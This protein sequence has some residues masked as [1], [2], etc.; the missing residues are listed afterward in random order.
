MM[1]SICTVY[2]SNQYGTLIVLFPM[3]SYA[4]YL[5]SGSQEKTKDYTDIKDVLDEAL[6]NYYLNEGMM[7]RHVEKH[8]KKI[9][10]HTTEF[11]GIKQAP[12]SRT[13]SWYLILLIRE[14]IREKQRVQFPSAVEQ[15]VKLKA[16]A[17]D[18]AVRKE[19][20]R[21]QMKLS[22]IID[23]ELTHCDGVF[24]L[25][26]PTK[27]EIE[28]RLGHQA[29]CRPFNTLN[30]SREFTLKSKANNPKHK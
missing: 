28:R 9:F 8:G 7:R 22:E 4:L 6:N 17:T 20:L 21:I 5:D 13:E 25:N 10:V 18:D 23:K 26:S 27:N 3:D 30:G 29:D 1:V 16:A 2:R 11:A 15:W 14:F 12:G 19:F 24:Y